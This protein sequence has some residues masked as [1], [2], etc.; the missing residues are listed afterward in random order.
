MIAIPQHEKMIFTAKLP[1]VAGALVIFTFAAAS[2]G[3]AMP[4]SDSQSPG[5]NSV[6]AKTGEMA[7]VNP[8]RPFHI[9][10]PEESLVDLPRRIVA[11]RWPDQETVADQSQ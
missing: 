1:A 6:P 5:V 4:A 7:R 2:Y 9:N 3:Q 10:V 8:T 11:T